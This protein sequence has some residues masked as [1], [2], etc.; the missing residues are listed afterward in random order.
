[1]MLSD[2]KY[3]KGQLLEVQK[4]EEIQLSFLCV[5]QKWEFSF[6]CS[7]IL[8]CLTCQAMCLLLL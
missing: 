7:Y 1:M 5:G 6:W 4:F 3:K 2:K 8:C